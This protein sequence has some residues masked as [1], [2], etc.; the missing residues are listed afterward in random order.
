MPKTNWE[1][2]AGRVI[3][4]DSIYPRGRLQFIVAFTYEVE[5]KV[6]EGTLYTFDSI[7]EGDSLVVK[8]D[9]LD[10]KRNDFETRQKLINRVAVAVAVPLAGA[11]LLLVWF[12]L[13]R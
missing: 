9:P 1:Q 2:T 6:Y 12:S 7:H 8:Y 3:H 10:P 13:R 11:A 4:I 5:G